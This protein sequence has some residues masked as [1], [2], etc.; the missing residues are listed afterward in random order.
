MAFFYL[1]MFSLNHVFR[2]DDKSR[3]GF[4]KT[5]IRNQGNLL[6]SAKDCPSTGKYSSTG[7]VSFRMP[8]VWGR[9]FPFVYTLVKVSAC[10]ISHPRCRQFSFTP[11]TY[12]AP[13]R[14]IWPLANS[15]PARGPRLAGG[16]CIQWSLGYPGSAK[17]ASGSTVLR[18]CL[19]SLLHFLVESVTRVT[20][21][22][23][24]Q[25]RCPRDK[26]SLKSRSTMLNEI[27]VC[28][29][30]TIF[31]SNFTLFNL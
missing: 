20:T 22:W 15:M 4:G 7:T 30:A 8:S 31:L 10:E 18:V 13:I 6:K 25:Q 23:C 5:Y 17:P 12:I 21:I 3:I 9:F 2:C 27:E 16:L 28:S 24:V 29:N 1:I 19:F 26:K 11:G 14:L